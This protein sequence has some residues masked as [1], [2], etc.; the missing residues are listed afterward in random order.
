MLTSRSVKWRTKTYDLFRMYPKH[1]KANSFGDQGQSQ[2]TYRH[3]NC[4]RG[5][6][7][8]PVHNNMKYSRYNNNFKKAKEEI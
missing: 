5:Q 3:V 8:V 6:V 1:S 7:T 4:I 2:Y